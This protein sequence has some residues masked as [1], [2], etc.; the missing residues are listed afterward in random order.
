VGAV[1]SVL[2]MFGT[3]VLLFYLRP[4][5]GEQFAS[6]PACFYLALLML[7]GQGEPEG[8]LPW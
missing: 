6:I 3:S 7:C 2:L 5:D 4:N 8:E 1:L